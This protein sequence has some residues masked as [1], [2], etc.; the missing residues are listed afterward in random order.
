[1]IANLWQD[2]R[3]AARAFL[4]APAFMILAILTIA[5][6]VGLALALSRTISS[7]LYNVA[8]NDPLTL[9]AVVVTLGAVALLASY[10]PARRAS[11]IAPTEALRCQ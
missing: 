10:L 5:I 1:M 4:R 3:Y 7:L 6:G 11:R 2:L 9:T 8:G